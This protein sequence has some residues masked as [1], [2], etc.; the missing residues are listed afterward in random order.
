MSFIDLTLLLETWEY[1]DKLITSKGWFSSSAGSSFNMSWKLRGNS[2]FSSTF[3]SF[4][5]SSCFFSEV[6]YLLNRWV[7]NIYCSAFKSSYS[8]FSECGGYLRFSLQQQTISKHFLMRYFLACFS[9]W[10][11]Y[12]WNLSLVSF[13]WMILIATSFL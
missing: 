12:A 3:Y 6:I 8:T 11:L 4:S 9:M 10:W 7:F 2:K 5:A 1:S 13:L